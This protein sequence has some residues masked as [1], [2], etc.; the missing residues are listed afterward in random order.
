MKLAQI[1]AAYGIS[2]VE[3]NW[4]KMFLGMIWEA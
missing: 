4:I 2:K 1:V 3:K